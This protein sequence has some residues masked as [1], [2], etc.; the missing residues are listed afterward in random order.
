MIPEVFPVLLNLVAGFPLAMSTLLILT[1]D[2]GTELA[3]AV[4][5]PCNALPALPFG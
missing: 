1:I 2:L 3:P 4:S 5:V